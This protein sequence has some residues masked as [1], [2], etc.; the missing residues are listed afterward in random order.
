MKSNR[1][2]LQSNSLKNTNFSKSLHH[3]LDLLTPISFQRLLIP[4]MLQIFLLLLLPL[5][6]LY[7]Q[8]TGKTIVL[9]T[10]PVDP[11]DARRGSWIDLS[12]DIS[13]PQTLKKLPGWNE[14]I[15]KFPGSHKQYYPVAEGTNLYVV[16]QQDKNK[17][18]PLRIEINLP[19][20]LPK[21]QIVMRGQYRYDLINYGIEKYYMSESDREQMN[22]E[23]SDGIPNRIGQLK[24]MLVETKVNHQGQ[25]VPVRM[26]VGDRIYN[27]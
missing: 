13:Y 6:N 19:K 11:Y 12:Y 5:P 23:I 7:T 22:Q 25:A 15:K 14:L 20:S 17:W 10:I 27:F 2:D 3:Q 18:K 8:F 1:S 26:Q 4:L 9:Q 21:D 16:M 24:P